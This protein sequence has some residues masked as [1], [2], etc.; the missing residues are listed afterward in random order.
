MLDSIPVE[1]S[2]TVSS[3]DLSPLLLFSKWEHSSSSEVKVPQSYTLGQ[4]PLEEWERKILSV[5]EC[6]VCV[7]EV[8]GEWWVANGGWLSK[9][10]GCQLVL[11]TEG[12]GFLTVVSLPAS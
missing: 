11:Q 5:L 9:S 4:A 2:L 3:P 7:C 8:G 12:K 10:S 1:S 6:V